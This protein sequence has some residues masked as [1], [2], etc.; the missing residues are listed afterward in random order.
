M[1][2]DPPTSKTVGEPISVLVAHT[3]MVALLC[4]QS[5]NIN[6]TSNYYFFLQ[7]SHHVLIL[8]F[9][10]IKLSIMFYYNH[11]NFLWIYNDAFCSVEL[12]KI[13]LIHFN[14]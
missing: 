14:R 7:F 13:M 2:S 6:T 10:D 11:F 3:I 4:L 5:K 1:T 9:H 8:D 12:F